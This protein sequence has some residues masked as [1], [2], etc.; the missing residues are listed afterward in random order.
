MANY[1][2]NTL[3]G[4]LGPVNSEL[5]KIEQSIEDKF[6]RKPSVAQSNELTDDLDANSN[7][8]INLGAP[9]EPNDAVRLK[10]L[11]ES[12]NESVL[13][14]QEGQAGEY[15]RTNGTVAF[16]DVFDAASLGLGNVDNTTDLNKPISTA[17]EL[18]L[19]KRATYVTTFSTLSS[20]SPIANE[21]Y[22][23][24]ERTGA[25]YI[26]QPSGYVALAGD[27]TFANLLI[28]ALQVESEIKVSK[29]GVVGDGA[30]D[31]TAAMT[32]VNTR[33]NLENKNI[34]LDRTNI[35]CDAGVLNIT[36][37][38]VAIYGY[39]AG[40]VASLF[41]A[42]TPPT[43]LTIKGVGVAIR[44]N[45]LDVDIK[46]FRL[47]SNAA[48][49]ALT[50]DISSA[51]I[52]I[53][54]DDVANARADRC[55]IE[56]VRI[57]KQAGDGVL[58]VG[59]ALYFNAKSVDIYECK[60]NGFRLNAGTKA[61]LIRANP[62]YVGLSTLES[63]RVGYCGGHTV[64]AS[65]AG[66]TTQNGMAVRLAIIDMDSFGNGINTSIMEPS[67]DGNFYGF[68]IFGENCIVERSA[69]SGWVG[70]PLTPELI[71]GVWIAGRDN[72][73][74][75]NRFIQC[76]Q[77]IYYGHVSAQ[78]STGLTVDMFRIVNATLTHT[79]CIAVQSAD[80]KG[81]RVTYDRVESFVNV[82]TRRISTSFVDSDIIYQ[83]QRHNLSGITGTGDFITVTDDS[84]YIIPIDG[85]SA[86]VGCQGLLTLTPS[87]I[88]V[89]GGIFHIRLA[90]TS[91]LATKWGGETNT[92]G[93]GG[94]LN[95]TTGVDGQIT[96][97][98]DNTNIYI[99]NRRGFTIFFTY[100]ISSFNRAYNIGY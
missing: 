27:V 18:E 14:P 84:V 33:A 4:I 16:W 61:G 86:A 72:T 51:G 12:N 15:L 13:P 26:V 21:V 59:N 73:L 3:T 24:T 93:A 98:C 34:I 42:D 54:P 96:V 97:S 38:G 69:P 79:D 20:L 2:R 85:M 76:I 41:P 19:N 49:A 35:L 37:D 48:R 7:R 87:S 68:W 47:T 83:G 29:F 17:T 22:V 60:G 78:P 5:Q 75:N 57:D 50:Y 43:T 56:H 28:G 8:I 94:V 45:A 44:V 90:A 53:E 55:T 1:T 80:S 40:N 58:L 99:E 23:C 62:H 30:T 71:G 6:D 63:C 39:G 52:R 74:R 11:Q 100:Q 36:S 70:I 31:D 32:L 25:E 65:D 66:V 9:S 95:G 10:D 91:P 67:A 64:V 88:T 92:V 82:A 89:G 81:L 46:G 77:P